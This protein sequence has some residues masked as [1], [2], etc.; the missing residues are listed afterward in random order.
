MVRDT[1]RFTDSERFK[2]SARLKSF[3]KWT[4]PFI[5]ESYLSAWGF[6]YLYKDDWVR[7]AFCGVQLCD[8]RPN[9]DP[10]LCHEHVSR[11]CRFARGAYAQNVPIES[12]GP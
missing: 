4:V 8:W 9:D 6:Y 12:E 3:D 2:E 5:S 1:G 10:L 11:H 7:C